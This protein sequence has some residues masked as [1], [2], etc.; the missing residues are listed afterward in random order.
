[1]WRPSCERSTANPIVEQFLRNP[2]NLTCQK[3]P[4]SDVRNVEG[5]NWFP[6]RRWQVKPERRFSRAAVVLL[7]ETIDGRTKRTRWLLLTRPIVRH[8]RRS[9][10]PH[11]IP[12]PAPSRRQFSRRETRARASMGP[13]TI[14]N[15]IPGSI[16]GI[17]RVGRIVRTVFKSKKRTYE[18]PFTPRLFLIMAAESSTMTTTN[19]YIMTRT[20]TRQSL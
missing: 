11:V 2:F 1:M 12:H 18:F 9:Q 17:R 16:E 3:Y 8:I 14:S 4:P 7:G 10:A 20:G 6:P 15:T 13:I 5:P 19:K